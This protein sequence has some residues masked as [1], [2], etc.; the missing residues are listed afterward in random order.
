M[1]H[2]NAQAY[3]AME[4]KPLGKFRSNECYP[5]RPELLTV[6][7]SKPEKTKGELKQFR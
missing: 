7:E 2:I 6:E 1:C 4:T 5:E 3:S